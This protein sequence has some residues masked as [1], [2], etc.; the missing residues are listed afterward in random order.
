MNNYKLAFDPFGVDEAEWMV[1]KTFRSSGIFD[2][3]IARQDYERATKETN[4][5]LKRLNKTYDG[6]PRSLWTCE[7]LHYFLLRTNVD[8]YDLNKALEVWKSCYK[9]QQKYMKGHCHKFAI[10]AHYH[11]GWPIKV[12]ICPRDLHP[13]LGGRLIHAAL[14]APNGQLFDVEGYKTAEDANPF[15]RSILWNTIEIDDFISLIND[16]D[17]GLSSIDDLNEARIAVVTVLGIDPNTL[18]IDNITD[19]VKH[20][21]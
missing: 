17:S 15:R 18:N 2:E 8:T 20:S 11:L 10:A 4:I 9:Q 21:I 6:L 12:L 1:W 3:I 16:S 14:E 19:P 7:T 13:G 5:L